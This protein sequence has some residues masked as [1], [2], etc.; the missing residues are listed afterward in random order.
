[1]SCAGTGQ[2]WCRLLTADD[3]A[4]CRADLRRHAEKSRAAELRSPHLVEIFRRSPKRTPS[5]H[6]PWRQY[7]FRFHTLAH[8]SRALGVLNGALIEP[9]A[10]DLQAVVAEVGEQV[11]LEAR[12]AASASGGPDSRDE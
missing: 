9:V 3:I 11:A 12:A 7:A 4:G 6:S 5:T 8:E 2:W 1:M 10:L